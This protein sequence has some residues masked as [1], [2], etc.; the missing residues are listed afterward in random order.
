MA[1][2]AVETMAVGRQRAVTR[3][4]TMTIDRKSEA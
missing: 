3:V 2:S 1:F 4:L